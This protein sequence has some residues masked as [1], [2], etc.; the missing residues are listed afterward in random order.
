L[1]P[2]VAY[3]AR[4]AVFDDPAFVDTG[5]TSGAEA[6]NIQASLAAQ[7]HAVDTFTGT[8]AAA[9]SGGLAGDRLLV[10][11][12][13]ELGDLGAALSQD[14]VH[15]IRSYVATGGGLIV[16]AA[17]AN[18]TVF[19]NTVFG[20]SL[21]AGTGGVT[22]TRTGE[23]A[24]TSFAGGP[25]SLAANNAIRSLAAASLPGGAATMYADGANATVVAFSYGNGEIVFLG[26]DWFDAEPVGTQN[27]GWLNVLNRAVAEVAGTGCTVSGTPGTD[28]LVGTGGSD[29]ICARGGNDTITAGGGN[30]VVFAG[31][32]ADTVNGQGGRDSIL[33]EAGNDVGFGGPG[34]D[35]ITGGSG[36]D[37][38]NGQDGRDRLDSRDGVRGN[39]RNNGGPGVDTCLR[40]RRD[41]ITSC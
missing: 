4:V 40:D 13:L 7:G 5:G 8:S 34:N 19:L 38:L 15:T 26:W 33:L 27:G 11:P 12:E 24:G 37:R 32:G 10:V 14:A 39:D 25:A 9:F 41:R 31:K 22:S 3:G 1:T 35:R 29:R 23:V 21:A 17:S 30:D 20:Y 2:A 6:D 18:T 28:T 36:G 16:S